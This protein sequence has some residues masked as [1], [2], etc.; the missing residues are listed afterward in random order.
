[1]R[2]P[3]VAPPSGSNQYGMARSMSGTEPEVDREEETET[4]QNNSQLPS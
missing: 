2:T 4:P 1:M 3:A